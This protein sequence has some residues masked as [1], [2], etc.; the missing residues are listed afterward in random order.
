[1]IAIYF[2]A[3]NLL[4]FLIMG[5]DK[6]KAKKHAWRIPEKTLFFVA[7]LGGSLGS[8]AGMYFFRHKTRHWYFVVG[9][10]AILFAQII[11]LYLL[12]DRIPGL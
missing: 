5:I 11:I 2:M 7:F 6:V 3:V 10:P 12:G 1:M 9:M 8:W 4:G